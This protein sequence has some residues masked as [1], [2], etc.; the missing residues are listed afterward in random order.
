M[1]SHIRPFEATWTVAQHASLAVEFSRQEYWSGLPCPSQ[2]IFP[3]QGTDP[4][5]FHLL[6][7]QAGSLSLVQGGKPSLYNILLNCHPKK[8]ILMYTSSSR[9]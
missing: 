5:P 9:A 8:D 4:H 2:G 7:W 6:H 1:L 3:T